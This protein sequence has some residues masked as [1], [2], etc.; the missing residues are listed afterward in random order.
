MGSGKGRGA[1][2][3]IIEQAGHL[4]PGQAG[5]GDRQGREGDEEQAEHVSGPSGQAEGPR[6][7]E[8]ETHQPV[9]GVK[10]SISVAVQG[11]HH[12]EKG[13]VGKREPQEFNRHRVTPGTSMPQDPGT[14]EHEQPDGGG[15]PE[16]QPVSLLFPLHRK[17]QVVACVR[18]RG[19][20]EGL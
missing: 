11:E 4:G 5:S 19:E 10:E 3:G 8:T 16:G 9:L 7:E 1:R 13:Q 17:T 20:G 12:P 18:P 15:G 6:K 2:P 14:G